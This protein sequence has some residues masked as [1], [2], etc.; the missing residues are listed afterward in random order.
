MGVFEVALMYMIK[1]FIEFLEDDNADLVY[2]ALLLCT[3]LAL[4]FTVNIMRNH[5]FYY[6]TCVGIILKKALGGVMYRKIMKY[7]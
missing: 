7:T 2:G 1:F 4:T 3:L 5:A 6:G